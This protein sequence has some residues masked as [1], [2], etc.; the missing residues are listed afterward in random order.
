MK[1]VSIVGARPQFI[2]IAPIS[3]ALRK[4]HTEVLVHTGQHYDE[5]MSD[6][7]FRE[8]VIPT[9]DIN[10]NIG[11]GSHATQTGSMLAAIEAVLL[12]E[13]PDVVLVL[14]DTNSTLAGALAAAKLHIPIAHVEAGERSFDRRMPEEINRIVADSLSEWL[15][16]ASRKA[17]ERLEF[18]RVAGRAYW[19]GD[20]MLDNLLRFL[21]LARRKSAIIEQLGLTPAR[22]ALLTIH[23]PANTDSPERLRSL[24]N[25]V[26]RV[27]EPV[28]FPIHP[29]TRAALEREG[30]AFGPH[31][32]MIAP[33]GYLDMMRLV[34]NAR[35]VATDSGGVQREAY[36]LGRPCITLRDET[37]WTETVEVGWNRLVGADAEMVLDAWRHFAPPAQLPPLFGMGD[38]AERIVGILEGDEERALKP[39]SVLSLPEPEPAL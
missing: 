9:P 13:K 4:R 31:V 22:Y 16:C 35:L 24:V 14:G 5:A 19:V 17:R 39:E 7:F 26:N 3:L 12:G 34:E 2:K 28:V 20:V 18:E 15:F 32:Q 10:L 29:R 38:A 21:P 1:I 11:S 6:I 23:R 36:Y 25:T 27:D 30:L 8:L 37:E 33:T